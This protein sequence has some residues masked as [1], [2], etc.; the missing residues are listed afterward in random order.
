[1]RDGAIDLPPLPCPYER[2]EA[3]RDSPNML[4]NLT[5]SLDVSGLPKE[6]YTYCVEVDGWRATRKM[7][8]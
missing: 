4:N 7:V 2:T 8:V 5:Q 1:M 3:V 6:R